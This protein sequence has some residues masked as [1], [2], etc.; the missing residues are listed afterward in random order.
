MKTFLLLPFLVASVVQADPLV[1]F[2]V[3]QP[4]IIPKNGQQ[5]TIKLIE[6]DFAFSYGSPEI[7]Q[8]TPPTDCGP[9]G[10][11]AA[12][13]LN[14][15]VTSNGT[16]FDRLATFTLQET[17]IWRTSTP[18][19]IRGDGIIWT[20]IKDVSRYTTLFAKPGTLILELDNIVQPELDGVY[21]SLV[22]V[23]FYPS[24]E[25]N[26][27]VPTGDLIIPIGSLASNSGAQVFF[28]PS[29]TVPVTVPQNTIEIYAEIYASGNSDEEFWYFNVPDEYLGDLPDGTTSGKGSFREVRLLLDGQLAGV[30]FPYPVIF[31]GGFVPTAWRPIPSYGA[32]DLPS[33]YV[34]LTPFVPLLT[35]GKPHNVTIDVA[36]ADPDHAINSNWILSAN[37]QVVTGSSPEPTTGN[38]TSYDVEPFARATST[39]SSVEGDVEITTEATRKLRIESQVVS[40]NGSRS[41]VVWSQDLTFST[42]QWFLNDTLVERVAQTSSGT[43]I[44]THNGLTKTVD[45]FS[46]PL[47]V[48]LTAFGPGLNSL[49]T[50]VDHSYER[51]FS[52]SPFVLSSRIRSHQTAGGY[53]FR[54]PNGTTGT[55]TSENQFSYDDAQGNTYWRRVNAAYNTITYNKEGGTLAGG[56]NDLWGVATADTQVIADLGDTFRL[57]GGRRGEPGFES[58]RIL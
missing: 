41:Q 40:G 7:V 43:S 50:T 14:L 48:N 26:P 32:L 1:D 55:G 15:T 2:Q 51:F 18:E 13:T 58:G 53:L 57:P 35:D 21:H 3:A 31:T 19:P 52:P 9:A 17:E 8:Y 5:C 46:Y 11:W 22:H 20:Y 56:Q 49:Q 6:R 54:G 4:P 27:P 34:D 29:L 42:T 24:T 44:S 30:A 37:L 23:T 25:E 12:V 39:L 45:K 16:Q 36:S 28:P 47:Q 33:Y 10:T 38:I